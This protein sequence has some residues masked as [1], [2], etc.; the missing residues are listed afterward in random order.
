M[1]SMPMAPERAAAGA[2][3]LD[4]KR[5]DW[6]TLIDIEDLDIASSTRCICG[7]LYGQYQEGL[8][9]LNVEHPSELGFTIGESR[10]GINEAWTYEV[11][12]RRRRN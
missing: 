4:E 3:F 6:F 8:L 10:Q 12:T 11:I 1:M 9:A 5:P 7:Q 2:T